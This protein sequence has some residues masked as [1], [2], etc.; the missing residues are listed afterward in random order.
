MPFIFHYFIY[1]IRTIYEITIP[2][3]TR[4][5]TLTGSIFIIL[6]ISSSHLRHDLKLVQLVQKNP[7]YT[8]NDGAA[9]NKN[10][11]N[12]IEWIKNNTKKDCRIISDQ[13]PWIVL[14]AE[15]WCVSCPWVDN[16]QMILSFIKSTKAEYLIV[17]P[18]IQNRQKYL[19][20]LLKNYADCFAQLYS[21][22]DAKIYLINKGML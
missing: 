9:H 17:A 1:G 7:F 2:K 6:L 5:L 19:L 20:P 3:T 16:Q 13:A 15:R 21:C 11:I 14:L 4:I 8:T 10:F 12:C 18:L 22:D